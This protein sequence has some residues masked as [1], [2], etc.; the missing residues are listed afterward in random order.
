MELRNSTHDD[1]ASVI[2]FTATMRLVAWF[3]GN[4]M[5][6]PRTFDAD[7]QLVKLIGESA[8]QRLID[9]WPGQHLS[10]PAMSTY[11]DDVRKRRVGLMLEK[12]FSTRAVSHL[13]RMSERRVQQIARELEQAGLIEVLGPAKKQEAK[14]SQRQMKKQTDDL[15]RK[16]GLDVLVQ[17]ARKSPGEKAP[18]KSASKK[19]GQKAPAK[20]AA[21][22][23]GQNEGV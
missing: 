3:G 12:G 5:F 11:D 22:I 1:L 16:S 10:V 21:A 23:G 13:E 18:A 4:N 17:M 20:K 15:A 14:L 8:A 19:V 7:T 2:G 9:E 6:V